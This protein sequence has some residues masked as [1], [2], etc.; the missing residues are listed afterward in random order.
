MVNSH[1]FDFVIAL[2]VFSYNGLRSLMVDGW[3]IRGEY[4][5]IALANRLWSLL[6][7][8]FLNLLK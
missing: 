2:D 5:C 6:Q 4:Q 3:Q 1:P 8:E 7:F